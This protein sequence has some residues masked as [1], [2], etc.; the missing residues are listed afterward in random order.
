MSIFQSRKF[1]TA[2]IAL[3]VIVLRGLVPDFPTNRLPKSCMC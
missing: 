1:W 3:F 2:A